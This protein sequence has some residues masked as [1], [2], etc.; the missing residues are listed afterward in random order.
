MEAL[1]VL[2][3]FLSFDIP[4]V[5]ANLGKFVDGGYIPLLLGAVI[6]TVMIVWNRGRSLLA[7]RSKLRYGSWEHALEHVKAKL[8]ARVPGTAVFMNSN[9][10]MLPVS[11]VRHVE[12]GRS[13]HES[14]ILLTV[15]TCGR[16]TVPPELTRV[17][18]RKVW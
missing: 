16:P 15:T 18:P 14:V 11:L 12:R 9:P 5:V 1:S 4:F 17:W 13:L 3:L 6:L 8:V 10:D 7:H 2:I